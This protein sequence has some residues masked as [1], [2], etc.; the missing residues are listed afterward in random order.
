MASAGTPF[1]GRDNIIGPA[2]Y[3]S[4]LELRLYTN[5]KNSLDSSTVFA[6]MTEPSGTGY[7]AIA[8][9]GTWSTTNGVVGYD[10][11]GGT[12]PSWTNSG[13][14]NWTGA[15]TGSFITDGTYVLHFKDFSVD[16]QTVIP[17]AVIQVDVSNLVG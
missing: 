15:V 16:P 8:M 14:G 4:S 13:G 10:H 17:G 7:A 5:T 6:D 1:E 9:T 2:V 11:G 3:T 12:N